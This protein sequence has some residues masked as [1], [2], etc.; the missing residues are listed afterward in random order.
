MTYFFLSK[1]WKTEEDRMQ[2][3]MNL[4]GLLTLEELAQKLKVERSWVYARTRETGSGSLPRI[5][6]G[7][8]LRFSEEAVRDWLAR[9]N[10]R[11]EC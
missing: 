1:Y 2:Q 5:K 10:T 4:D 3:T 6:C 7:K 11:E 9:A 8:Y